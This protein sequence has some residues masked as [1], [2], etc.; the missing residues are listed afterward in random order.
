VI[1]LDAYKRE[2]VQHMG[3]QV[4]DTVG[5]LPDEWLCCVWLAAMRA[6][7]VEWHWHLS[8]HKLFTRWLV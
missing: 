3:K 7:A 4:S 1:D 2:Q 5:V 6:S 8:A